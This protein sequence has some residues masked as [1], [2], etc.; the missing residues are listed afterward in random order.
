MGKANLGRGSF[1]SPTSAHIWLRKRKRVADNAPFLWLRQEND[2]FVS[3]CLFF[4]SFSLKTLIPYANCVPEKRMGRRSSY[5]LC[6]P[7]SVSLCVRISTY[8]A[9]R[10]WG[11]FHAWRF[12]FFIADAHEVMNEVSLIA[13]VLQTF[14][15]CTWI[16][17][18][19]KLLIHQC[20]TREWTSDPLG[21]LTQIGV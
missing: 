13:F 12:F 20:N 14:I 2:H 9:R 1:I 21:N 8:Q 19:Q 17:A 15:S 7:L 10:G 5:F 11:H 6:R 3:Y 4:L 16:M 18:L